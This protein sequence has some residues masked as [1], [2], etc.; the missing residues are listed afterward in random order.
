MTSIRRQLVL[1]LLVL[2]LGAG[3]ISG[4]GLY[5]KIHEEADRLFDY[6]L[7]ELAL[8]LRDQ[9]LAQ[10]TPSPADDGQFDI[11]IQIWNPSGE[12]IYLS[13]PQAVLPNR[14]RLGFATVATPVGAWR[15]FSIQMRDRTIQVGQALSVRQA[16][17]Q[18]LALRTLLPFALL[19]PLLGFLVWG[20]VGRGLQ[21]LDR[22]AKEVASRSPRILTPL[23]KD[24]LPREIAPLVQAL[25]ELLE[26]LNHSTQAQ[27]AFIADAAHELRTPLTAVQLQAQVAER[28][29]TD[30]QRSIAFT[31][32]NSGISRTIHLAQ[33]LLMLARQEP[34][35]TIRPFETVNLNQLARLSIE[36]LLPLADAK[37]I[38]LGMNTDEPAVI[39]GDA[40]ALRTMLTNLIDNAIRYVPE[41][42]KIDVAVASNHGEPTL[43][44]VDNGPGIP[45]EEREHVLDRFYR[46]DRSDASGSGLGLAIVK[47]VAI[48]HQA[49]L[50][51]SQDEHSGGLRVSVQFPSSTQ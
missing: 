33:Q 27:R 18:T 46:R 9:V 45:P 40:E 39:M 6:H 42:G 25:N 36:E 51:L 2:L 26:R 11:I 37:N 48:R 44:V 17:A 28:A 3:V 32:L 13:H 7:Q 23:A 16:L 5:F 47:N 15:V 14:A 10:E 19:L 4:T 24:D 21:P 41:G 29:T 43:S 30:A 31:Q 49:Q 1:S 8:S 12:R 35:V 34:E 38:D 50:T 20:I 22:V